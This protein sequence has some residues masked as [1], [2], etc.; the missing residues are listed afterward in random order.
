MQ[1]F[2]LII[3]DNFGQ[4]TEAELELLRSYFKEEKLSRNAYFT[5]SDKVCDKLSLIK[6]GILRVYAVVDG[7]EITQ[8]ISTENYLITEIAGFFFNQPNRWSI[9]A[10][11]DVELL[12]L[13]K[14]IISNSAR[15]FPSG[16]ILKKD[17]SSNVLR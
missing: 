14:K 5:Q 17:S 12:T 3:Q 9:Q 2:N 11:T 7:K 4:L 10:F 6:S 15:N 1:N 16:S 13:S 8:W